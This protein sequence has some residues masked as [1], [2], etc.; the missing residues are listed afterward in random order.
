MICKREDKDW[1]IDDNIVDI[2]RD[3][4]QYERDNDNKYN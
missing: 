2:E 3:I 1:N 4:K